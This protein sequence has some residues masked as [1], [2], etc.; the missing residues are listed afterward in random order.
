MPG[1]EWCR[2]CRAWCPSPWTG[3]STDPAT[4]FHFNTVP[5]TSGNIVGYLI[6]PGK[7][8]PSL[9]N[10]GCI[11]ITNIPI[12]SSFLSSVVDPH[13]FQCPDQ[14]PGSQTDEDP[15][16]SGSWSDFIIRQLNFNMKNKGQNTYLRRYKRLFEGRKPGLLVTFGQFPCSWI[17]IPSRDPDPG[18]PNQCGIHNTDLIFNADHCCDRS[19]RLAITICMEK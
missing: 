11:K 6:F 2:S 8:K 14:D 15:C 7:K 3:S 10:S 9:D 4:H 13:R 16:G 17:R 19:E 12:F 18:Q 5:Y 1:P